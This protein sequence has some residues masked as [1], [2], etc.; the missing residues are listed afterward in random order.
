MILDC[1]LLGWKWPYTYTLRG[2]TCSIRAIPNTATKWPVT[3]WWYQ[4][5]IGQI[6]VWCWY[7]CLENGHTVQPRSI[8]ITGS[9]IHCCFGVVF[10]VVS[11]TQE[12]YR[13][14]SGH[15]RIPPWLLYGEDFVIYEQ[16]N[17]VIWLSWTYLSICVHCTVVFSVCFVGSCLCIGV[18][19]RILAVLCVWHHIWFHSISVPSYAYDVLWGLWLS[20]P[21]AHWLFWS[22]NRQSSFW[23]RFQGLNLVSWSGVLANTEHVDP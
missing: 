6:H 15:E 12:V 4:H 23:Q 22:D 14:G 11:L 5:N 8:L 10:F 3:S 13:S 17:Q 9:N 19:T 21:C 1:L 7:P 2:A 16:G 20:L 18:Y